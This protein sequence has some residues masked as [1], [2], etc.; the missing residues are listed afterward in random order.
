MMH[1]E[2]RIARLFVGNYG[3]RYVSVTS[4]RNLLILVMITFMLVTTEAEQSI[5]LMTTNI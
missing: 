5:R 4:I 3:K 1:I 2:V